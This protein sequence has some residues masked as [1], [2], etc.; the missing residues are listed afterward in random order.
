MFIILCYNLVFF[1]RNIDFLGMASL[2]KLSEK[3]CYLNNFLL[4]GLSTELKV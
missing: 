1:S 3:I 4:K 2:D